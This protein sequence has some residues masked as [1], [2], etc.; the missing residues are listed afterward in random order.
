MEPI[1][2][3][4]NP[5]L[6][7]P[8]A[9]FQRLIRAFEV[10]NHASES[11]QQSYNELQ[12]EAHRLAAELAMANAE[13]ERSLAEKESFRNY[14]KNIL[15][16]LSNGVLV[17]DRTERAAVCNPA[18][19]A[20][21]CLS[22]DDVRSARS[23]HDLAIP[24]S[25]EEFITAARSSQV[26]DPP[27]DA[28]LHWNN[29]AGQPQFLSVSAS[30]VADAQGR[31]TGLTIVLKDITRLKELE[32]QTQ[33]ARQL[34]A[35]G[36]MAVQLAHE[37][38]NPLGS[39]ELF[40]SLLGKE[41]RNQPDFKGWADQIVTGV[42]FLNSIVTNMLTF[43]RISKPQTSV[44]EL[45]ALILET[46]AFVEPVLQQ[47]KIRLE[48]PTTGG[49]A[50]L[51]M[52]D[53]GMLRQMFLNLFMNALQAMPESG[54][55]AVRVQPEHSGTVQVEVEDNGIGIPAENLSRVFDPF[56]TTHEKGTGLGLALVHQIVEKHHGRIEAHSEFGK[57]TRFTIW[58][59]E[60]Q[61]TGNDE[62]RS[63]NVVGG[64]GTPS[65]V[66]EEPGSSVNRRQV[67]GAALYGLLSRHSR[68]PVSR[69]QALLPVP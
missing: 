10:F 39:I 44:L 59:P 22:P 28:E 35:M 20:L 62:G 27:P 57:G 15:E 9:D 26:G 58:L 66:S 46:L 42:K 63:S 68:S 2:P 5:A 36:E 31:N 1:A 4:L 8:N 18:A 30:P 29:V 64:K 56:F 6:A 61:G 34:Q 55:L 32:I 12:G 19:V 33:R 41:L 43:T 37:I 25:L 16:S 65:T 69:G 13:L 21:L 45:R 67:A 52:G 24:A 23:Y 53:S 7:D 50:L 48:R 14:L 51:C 17:I 49:D 11:L 3:L 60:A 47:R 54:R 38:R 40:A